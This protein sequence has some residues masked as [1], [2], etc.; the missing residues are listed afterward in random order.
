MTLLLLINNPPVLRRLV[1][2]ID[3]GIAA[4]KISSPITNAEALAMPYLQAVIREGL[5]LFP[6]GT[7]A[8]YKQVPKGGDTIHGYYLPEGTQVGQNLWG[9]TH[10]KNVFGEDADQFRPERWLTA[11]ADKRRIMTDTTEMVFG[12]GKYLCLGKQMALVE[13]NKIFVEVCDKWLK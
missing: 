10:S 5:R 11:N 12:Y 2:E 7:G 3:A 8:A 1:A 9:I 13:L 6:P 4:G